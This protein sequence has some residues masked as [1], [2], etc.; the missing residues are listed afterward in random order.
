MSKI[1]II[2][3]TN[4]LTAEQGENIKKVLGWIVDIFVDDKDQKSSKKRR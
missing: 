1:K 4:N 2:N 3:T